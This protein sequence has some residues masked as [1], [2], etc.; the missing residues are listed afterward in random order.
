MEK[1]ARAKY[2]PA[3]PLYGDRMITGSSAHIA[4][5]KQAASEGIVLLK[6]E[7]HVLPLKSGAKL[8][9]FGKGVFDY[10]KG[11]G[12]SGDVYARYIRNLYEG[13]AETDAEIYAPLCDFYRDY[14]EQKYREKNAPGMI[15]EPA[16]DPSMIRSAREF[17]DTAV[18]C[19]SRFSGEGWDRSDVEYEE[20]DSPWPCEESMPQISAKIFPRGDF[21]LSAQEEQLLNDIC[22]VFDRVIAVLNIGGVIDTKWITANDRIKAALLPW[23]GGMEGAVATAQTIMGLYNPSGRLPDTFAGELSDYPST[24]GFHDSP[25]YV[26]YTEDIYVG[27]RYFE[28]IEGAANR[29]VFPFGYGLSYTSFDRELI[30]ARRC[31]GGFSFFVRVINTGD[32]AGKDVIAL[33]LG[34]PC[35][36]LGKPAR[37]LVAY[38]KTRLLE[39]GE[40]ETLELSVSDYQLSSYDDLGKISD[41]SYVIEQG[42]YR[43]FLGGNVRDAE[44]LDY[45]YTEP[46]DRVYEKLSHH[47]VPVS[48]EKRLLS[49]GSYEALPTGPEKD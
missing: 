31:D 10:V 21:Y 16:L 19:L 32:C 24:E 39:K 30:T 20:E 46:A 14:V 22:A 48:L 26:A 7:D 17:T 1:W 49:D 9:L 40:A 18:F 36:K 5:S 15:A 27:Y 2:Q 13:F 41:A 11:G 34:A 3:R 25:H 44:L 4:L 38:A 45:T 29:V 28:T 6:N 47:L 12:G 43:F 37:Q 35:G 33:Y 8:A 23:Q 42:E